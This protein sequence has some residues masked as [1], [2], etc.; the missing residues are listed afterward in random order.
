[1]NNLFNFFLNAIKAILFSPFYILYFVVVLLIGL[2]NHLIG[3]VRILLSGFK[4]ATD[5][6]N[7]YTKK[8][9]QIKESRNGGEQLW[10][11]LFN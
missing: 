10:C 11:L 4:Y 3:E 8:L 7:K 6:E 9:Q 1:M 2:F 5:K